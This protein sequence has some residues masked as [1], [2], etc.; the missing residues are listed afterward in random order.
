MKQDM[1]FLAYI[2]FSVTIVLGIWIGYQ[3]GYQQGSQ[4]GY[5][6]RVQDDDAF[7]KDNA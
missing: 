6:L 7:E 5:Y 4:D 1:K 2:L 3:F